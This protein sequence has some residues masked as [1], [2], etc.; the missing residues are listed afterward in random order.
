MGVPRFIIA[1]VAVAMTISTAAPA[2]GMPPLTHRSGCAAHLADRFAPATGTT[3]RHGDLRV[4]GV[5][6]KQDVAN[7][8]SYRSFRTTMRCLMR[9]LVLPNERR[10]E[11]TLVVFNEDI[12]LM[13]A[14]TGARG[15]LVRQQATTGAPAGD[16]EPVDA[17]TALAELNAEYAPQIAAYQARFGP[18]DPR[19]QLFVGATDTFARAFSITFSRLARRYGVYVVAS[20][21]QPRYR[22]S[23]DPADI[24]M[25]ADPA[26]AKP[27]A[28]FVAT[29]QTVHNT[30]YLWGPHVVKPHAPQ[31]ER[32]LLFRN[33]KVPLTD[34]EAT[35]LDLDPGPSTGKAAIRNARGHV[36]AGH[37]LGFATSLPAFVYGYPIGQRPRH[38]K[39][40]ADLSVT[41]MACMDRLGVDTLVQ[42][43]A[44]PGR[45]AANGGANDWQ[46]LDW[47]GS[48]WRAVADPTVHFRYA[49]NPMMVGNL[50]D[51]DFDGQSA[52]LARHR[53]GRRQ[54]YVGDAHLVPGDGD[55]VTA[56]PYIGGKSQFL[57]L[58]PWVIADGSRAKLRAEGA[59]LAAGSGDPQENDYLETAVYADLTPDKGHR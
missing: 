29:S 49:I 54:H 51:L 53:D 14:A 56:K 42:A 1:A 8:R 45:W 34:L 52:I 10:G 38:F 39:P 57:A 3:N 6:Y 48:A 44:N 37:R 43:E 36:V 55:P 9:E 2:A 35:L 31:G 4:I 26:I 30:T 22:Q 50:L 40:C 20:N 47:M 58:A 24:A 46:P 27:K 12:G 7:V 19:K 33:Y 13:T 21:N 32:N 59:R 16:G 18:I 17:A 28:A 5:Q 11:K 15:K 23:T 41:Y 25:F